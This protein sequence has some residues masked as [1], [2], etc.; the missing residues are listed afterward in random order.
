MPASGRGKLPA[1]R[2]KA[3]LPPAPS[4]AQP[5]GGHLEFGLDS[6][7]ATSESVFELDPPT[8]ERTWE[9][10]VEDDSG[11]VLALCGPSMG[12]SRT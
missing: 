4:I 12:S 11:L 5:F 9:V 7:P 10:S 1:H 2:G 3:L 8:F 6:R